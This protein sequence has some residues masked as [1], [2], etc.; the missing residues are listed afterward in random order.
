M[1]N[2]CRDAGS[3]LWSALFFVERLAGDYLLLN[4]VF[5][6]T[7]WCVEMNTEIAAGFQIHATMISYIE[8][9]AFI[10]KA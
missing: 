8:I 6:S 2:T 5:A 4:M 1:T 9:A 7:I 10:A 3:A